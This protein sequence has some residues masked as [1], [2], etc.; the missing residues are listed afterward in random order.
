MNRK[1]LIILG[2]VL[3]L[4]ILR[5]LGI[6]KI[7][8]DNIKLFMDIEKEYGYS[9]LLL[10][11]PLSIVQGVVTLFPI[12]TIITFHTIVFG[13]TEGLLYSFIGSFLGS[14]ICFILGRY[15]FNDWSEKLWQK[16]KVK[17]QNLERY[18]Q[19]YGMWG[20]ILLRTTPIMPSNMISLMAALSPI[21]F[22]TY[23][24][25][26]IFGNISM[27]W[28]L[29]ILGMSLTINDASPMVVGYIIY[30]VFLFVIFLIQLY[31]Q[32]RY[33]SSNERKS[34]LFSLK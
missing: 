4:I 30:L 33:K 29:G 18:F 28:L 6:D 24:W 8:D 34:K 11:I 15:F 17:Y 26:C 12:I 13:V 3:L 23:L 16:K 5:L 25:S 7:I 32:H 31:Y 21:S 19:Q 22:R 9:L 1:W 27:V 2:V 20:L 14:I 10:T